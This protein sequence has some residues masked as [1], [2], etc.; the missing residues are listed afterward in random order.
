LTACRRFCVAA[1]AVLLGACNSNATPTPPTAPART[2]SPTASSGANPAPST[3]FDPARLTIRLDPVVDGLNSPLA[4]VDADDGSGRLFVAERP[5]LIRI[6]KDGA[7][8]DVPFLDITGRILSGDERGLLGLAFAPDFPTD[9]RLFVN[10]TDLS[11]NTVVSS[12]TVPAATP[13]QADPDS[14]R[15]LLQ[16][17]QPFPNHNGGNLAFGPDGDLY[18]GTGDGGSGGDP[19]GNGQRLSTLLGK[20]LRIRVGA[21]DGSGP[22]YTIPPDAPFANDPTAQPEIRAFGLRNPWRFSF[23]RSTGDLWIGDVG[24]DAWEEVDVIRAADSANVAPNF[25]WNVME[26]RHCYGTSSCNQDGLVLPVA[27]YDHGF[28][29]AI[30]GGFVGRD[31][32]EPTLYGGYVFGDDCTG[33]IWVLDAARP[34]SGAPRLVLD[35]GRTISSFGEDQAGRLYLTDLSDGT[36]YRLV[37]GP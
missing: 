3:G 12:F 17:N 21:P 2:G 7:L 16:V 20:L 11:G 13:D 34:E 36:L 33:N 10:Y 31:P 5:G 14:E 6:V 15:I 8:A 28:G 19:L 25:G 9:P 32:S 23:D 24:Q 18:I 37:P 27:E 29:C 26:G 22:A 1:L 30:V 4:V 35:S